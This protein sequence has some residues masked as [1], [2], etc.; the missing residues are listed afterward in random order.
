MRNPGT[1]VKPIAKDPGT[2]PAARTCGHFNQY[3][4]SVG[5]RDAKGTSHPGWAGATTFDLAFRPGRASATKR[6]AQAF[7]CVR[8]GNVVVYFNSIEACRAA[9]RPVMGSIACVLVAGEVCLEATVPVAL[10]VTIQPTRLDWTPTIDLAAHPGCA[11]E[12]ARWEAA[13][14]AHEAH[15][16]DHLKALLEAERAARSAGTTVVAC[17]PMEAEA[18]HLGNFLQRLRGDRCNGP[19][20][21]CAMAQGARARP[22]G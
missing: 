12:K 3:A 21:M 17:A 4:R 11:A 1:I 19:R 13:V 5:V 7:R 6:V 22:G 2:P 14:A 9:C 18:C 15:H 10:S 16:V 8:S 20:R